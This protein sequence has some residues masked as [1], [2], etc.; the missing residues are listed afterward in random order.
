M[1]DTFLDKFNWTMEWLKQPGTIKFLGGIAATLGFAYT[2]ADLDKWIGATVAFSMLVNGLYDNNG[3][4]PITPAE[5]NKSLTTAEIAEL[6]RLRKA[7]IALAK[8]C[9]QPKA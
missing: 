6:V 3:R 2:Q 5:L 9:P 4:R 1:T 7:D 8:E